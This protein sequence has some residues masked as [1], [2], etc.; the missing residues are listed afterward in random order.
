M[1]LDTRKYEKKH[2]ELLRDTR[3][4]YIR[5]GEWL[6]KP[7]STFAVCFIGCATIYFYDLALLTGDIILFFYLIF[8]WWLLTRS[9][10]LAFKMPLGA[11]YKDPRNS[12]PGNSGKAEGILYLG[13]VDKTNEEVWFTNS[14]A[15]THIL[16][17]GTTGAGKTE[18]LKSMVTNALTWASGFVYIDGKADTDL[19][20][21][22]SS[23]VRRF[24]RDDDLLVLNYMTGNSD[25]KA[26]SNTM[27]PFSSGSASY[28]TNLL[29]SLMPNAE[30]DN[31]MWKERAVALVAALMPV[32][33]WK[34]DYQE[35]PLSVSTIRDALSL[36]SVIRYSRDPA[37]PDH[38]KA[39]LRGYLDTLP[40]YIDSAFDDD[41]KEKPAGPDQPMVD[42]TTPRQQHGYLAMQ[43]TRSLQSLGDDYGYIFDTQAADVDMLDIVLNRRILVVLIP[44]LEKSS[45]ETA[46]LGKIVAATIKGMMGSTLGSTV[47]GESATVI[48]NK[49]TTSAT[50]FMTVFDEVGYYTAQGMAVMAAQARSLGFC[51]IYSAQDLP[52]MEKRVKEEA[53]SITANC[54]IKI[55]GKLEDPT[56][57]KEF[58]EKTVGSTLV[59]EASGFQLSGGSASTGSYYD[60]KQAGLQIRARASYDALRGFKAGQACIA[61]GDMVI[62]TQI[63]YCAPGFAKAMRVQ[64]FVALPPPDEQLLR[65]AP[66]ITKV[67]D[68]LVH[69]T[70]TAAKAE[71]KTPTPDEIEAMAGALK[72]SEKAKLSG[73]QAGMAAVAGVHILHNPADLETSSGNAGSTSGITPAAAGP[74]APSAPAAPPLTAQRPATPPAGTSPI[75]QVISASRSSG[76]AVPPASVPPLTTT[77]P[78]PPPAAPVPPP[79]NETPAA[80]SGNP[81]S[82]F[83]KKPAGGEP[84]AAPAPVAA[85]VLPATTETP[86][87]DAAS[88]KSGKPISWEEL[89][90]AP[91]PEGPKPIETS[92]P[93]AAPGSKAPEVDDETR[94]IL[95]RAAKDLQDKIGGKDDGNAS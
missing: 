16:Y 8:L 42:T 72:Y 34:R 64:R 82:F 93:P 70:W 52:A 41:G 65:N 21:S 58:F 53:R 28:L 83:A 29:V 18:G 57:T 45:D 38:L 79:T 46:N 69:K 89:V 22:L 68:L 91:E 90:N 56:Q 95:E 48:E 9:R 55:F 26:P 25:T 67:R 74:A 47:E 3:P 43:F 44:A 10:A 80:A 36:N 71:P 88:G 75:A 2:T 62:D 12:G 77:P 31:A 24:G 61:F 14:D 33:T 27:N 59:M 39:G 66:V 87:A 84:P 40:G 6:K 63:F 20:S 73:T 76:N 1:A 11:K 17:L 50:P 49:V 92:P 35:I 15:R 5:F 81:M 30:G 32:M 13:N 78:A 94:A 85:P 37:V 60:T 4:L 19:W 23:L 86:A 54:N 7:D 51:L